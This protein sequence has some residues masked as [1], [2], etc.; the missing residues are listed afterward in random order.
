LLNQVS[1]SSGFFISEC[2]RHNRANAEHKDDEDCCA[3]QQNTTMNALCPSQILKAFQSFATGTPTGEWPLRKGDAME[4][5]I[6][7]TTKEL[8]DRYQG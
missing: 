5:E 2:R 1:A 6:E 8:D 7:E 4:V 3:L